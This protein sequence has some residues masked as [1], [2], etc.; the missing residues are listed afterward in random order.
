MHQ[1]LEEWDDELIEWV[2][3]SKVKGRED[4]YKKLINSIDYT[5]EIAVKRHAENGLHKYGSLMN[6]LI[7]GKNYSAME[8]RD[9]VQFF[10]N[11]GFLPVNI[12]Y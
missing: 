3:K 11:H 9:A 6:S 2:I 5:S 8:A 10:D 12:K 7:K 4:T 1:V